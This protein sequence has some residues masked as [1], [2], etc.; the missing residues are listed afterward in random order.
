MLLIRIRDAIT[1]TYYWT[2]EHT[3]QLIIRHN[4]IVDESNNKTGCSILQAVE[5]TKSSISEI[6][7]NLTPKINHDVDSKLF[8][9]YNS[10]QLMRNVIK[11]LGFK[12]RIGEPNQDGFIES[13]LFTSKGVL[14][15]LEVIR[16]VPIGIESGGG[17]TGKT[18]SRKVWTAYKDTRDKST[19]VFVVL[20]PPDV[21]TPSQMEIIDSK[22]KSIIIPKQG[23]FTI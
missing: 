20:L 23:D 4:K 5:H 15:L 21:V 19:L 3:A 22:Y 6:K 7:P 17:K 18:I 11:E 1:I 16:K 13:S 2:D 9:V 10:E 12:T 8:R 14:D